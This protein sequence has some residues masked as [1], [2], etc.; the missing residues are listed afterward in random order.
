[1]LYKRFREN[2]EKKPRFH[3]INELNLTFKI[4]S[5][6]TQH[7]PNNKNVS[8]PSTSANYL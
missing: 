2:Y 4:L 3:L 6:R 5:T 1:M 8:F 7:F